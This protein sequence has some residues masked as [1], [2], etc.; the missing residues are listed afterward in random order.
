[1]HRHTVHCSKPTP[2]YSA[3]TTIT[4][5][6]CTNTW[7]PDTDRKKQCTVA[8]CTAMMWASNRIC[9]TC[10][11]YIKT[12]LFCQYKLLS[13]TKICLG[14]ATYTCVPLPPS[15][16]I[17]YRPRGVI[18]LAG[19]V[20]AG[21]LESNDILP[22]GLWLSHLRADCQ[23]TWIS[24]VPNAHNRVW[25]YFTLNSNYLQTK[26]LHLVH[27]ANFHRTAHNDGLK[28]TQHISSRQT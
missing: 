18:S 5:Q 28:L 20:N 14:Q 12:E 21:L 26:S 25:D 24:S 6:P 2:C 19:K 9:T 23:E 7:C 10:T 16:I 15:S 1:M 8:Q 13:E 17:W 22:P 3:E 27:N 4:T 11:F